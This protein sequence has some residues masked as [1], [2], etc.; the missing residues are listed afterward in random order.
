[1]DYYKILGISR[2]ASEEDIK[3]AYRRLS[4]KYHPDANIG[5]KA[6]EKLF[7]E[8]S[9]AYSVLGDK[10][11]RRIYDGEIQKDAKRQTVK[12]GMTQKTAK[13]PMQFDFFSMGFNFEKY[14]G[15][16][17]KEAKMDEKERKTTDGRTAN[18]IDTSNLFERYMGFQGRGDRKK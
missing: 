11:K 8:I 9:E 15:F 5:N 6:A 2:E 3:K 18:P 12:S 7:M 1:M 13:E 16:P 17:P 4:K 10:E 14:F